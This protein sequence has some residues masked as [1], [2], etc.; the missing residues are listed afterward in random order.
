MVE[1]PVPLARLGVNRPRGVHPLSA[2]STG[3]AKAVAL[4]P[5]EQDPDEDSAKRR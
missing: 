2:M 1:P 3:R 5:G 4:P